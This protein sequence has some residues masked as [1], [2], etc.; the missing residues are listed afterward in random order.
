MLAGVLADLHAQILA[1]EE[2]IK[3]K[4]KWV[5]KDIVREDTL[6]EENTLEA[7]VGAKE[8]M[9][10]SELVG[11]ENERKELEQLL[12]RLADFTGTKPLETEGT[13]KKTIGFGR[14]YAELYGLGAEFN[15]E[16]D[17]ENKRFES[18][19]DTEELSAV[20]KAKGAK[21]WKGD[22]VTDPKE[23]EK[24]AKKTNRNRSVYSGISA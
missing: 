13:T 20:V 17:S 5:V 24:L 7:A 23:L 14:K 8:I 1:V 10:T 6:A 11:A 9:K 21:V 18:N 16:E 19:I 15:P 4:E 22:Q 2:S 12:K 3:Q